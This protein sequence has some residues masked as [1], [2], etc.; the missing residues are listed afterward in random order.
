MIEEV[1]KQVCKSLDKDNSGLG[2]EHVNRVLNLSLKFAEIENA[3]KEVV[4][5]IAL[6]HD[7]DEVRNYK[8]RFWTNYLEWKVLII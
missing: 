5:L 3:N 4:S 1:K 2:M 6:L 7:V 8:K